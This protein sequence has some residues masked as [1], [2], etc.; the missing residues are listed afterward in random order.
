MFIQQGD[1]LRAEIHLLVMPPL[2]LNVRDRLGLLRGADA[3]RSIALLPAE[4]WTVFLAK[5]LGRPSF[6]QLNRLGDVQIRRD[7]DEDVG[8]ILHSSDG[9][10]FHPVRARDAAHVGPEVGFE[11]WGDEAPAFLSAEYT[12]DE[13]AGMSVGHGAGIVRRARRVRA[14]LFGKAFS[15]PKRDLSPL[16]SYPA[17]KR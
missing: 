9:D 2:V 12:V 5:P 4:S 14:S 1:V 16:Q 3:E 17:L 15:R 13:K 10:G 7:S 11:L 6:D 8:V